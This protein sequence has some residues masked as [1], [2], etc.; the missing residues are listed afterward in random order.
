[1]H[2]FPHC[3]HFPSESVGIG[4]GA[5]AEQ[6]SLSAATADSTQPVERCYEKQRSN[7]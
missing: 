1:M 2:I 4:I 5:V 6:Y 3:K 7:K